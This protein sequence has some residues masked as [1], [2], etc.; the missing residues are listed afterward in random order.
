MGDRPDNWAQK[1][2]PVHGV[3]VTDDGTGIVEAYVAGVGNTDQQNEI[4]EPGVMGRALA[5]R[6][7]KGVWSHD[8]S[9]PVAKTLEAR[10]VAA[11]DASLPAKLIAAGAGGAYVRMQFNLATQRGREAY[12][13]V[14]FYGPEQE[15]SIGYLVLDAEVDEMGK[16]RLKDLDWL[17]YSPVVFGANPATAT[18]SVKALADGPHEFKGRDDDEEVCAVCGRKKETWRHRVGTEKALEDALK[19][20][21]MDG[22]KVG[23]VLS[24]ANEDKIAQAARLLEQVLAAVRGDDEKTLD[25]GMVTIPPSLIFEAKRLGALN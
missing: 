3:K 18:A 6:I 10:E 21:R 17:E 9:V 12:E 19:S 2:L 14:K 15:W 11:G 25:D 5:R 23:R 7:P 8:T 24:K 22:T 16:R 13:D 20:L 1:A 4:I